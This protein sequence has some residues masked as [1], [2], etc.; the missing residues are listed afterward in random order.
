MNGRGI[1]VVSACLAL[2]AGCRPSDPGP[3]CQPVGDGLLWQIRRA[4]MSRIDAAYA[5]PSRTEAA[6]WLAA[7]ETNRGVGVWTLGLPPD[8]EGVTFVLAA[9]QAARD[10]SVVGVDIPTDSMQPEVQAFKDT[11]GIAAAVR[12]VTERG[13]QGT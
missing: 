4:S 2:L 9:N 5:V 12:C 8:G 3:D 10:D 1:I 13:I 11:E 6:V 7:A